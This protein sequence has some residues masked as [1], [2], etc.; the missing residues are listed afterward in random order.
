MYLIMPLIRLQTASVMEYELGMRVKYSFS[1][2]TRKFILAS[3]GEFLEC[4]RRKTNAHIEGFCKPLE[5]SGDDLYFN[6]RQALR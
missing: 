3:R 2:K 6:I 1:H 4:Y 5:I